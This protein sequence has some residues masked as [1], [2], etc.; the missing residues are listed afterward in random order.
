MRDAEYFP[1]FWA[2][3]DISFAEQAFQFTAPYLSKFFST[4]WTDGRYIIL[5]SAGTRI[6]QMAATAKDPLNP[7]IQ[8]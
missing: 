8:F 1:A 3:V 5:S 6:N 7:A 2:K 4:M